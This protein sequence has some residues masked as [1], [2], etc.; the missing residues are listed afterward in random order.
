MDCTYE[1]K[2]L[3]DEEKTIETDSMEEPGACAMYVSKIDSDFIT[4]VE[5]VVNVP[6]HILA[7]SC[8]KKRASALFFFRLKNGSPFRTTIS[9]LFIFVFFFVFLVTG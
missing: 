3:E 5:L 7:A 9:R 2:P 8:I 6:S 1:I 4:H